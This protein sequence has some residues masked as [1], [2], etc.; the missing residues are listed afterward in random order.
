MDIEKK[1]KEIFELLDKASN[2]VSELSTYIQVSNLDPELKGI[3]KLEETDYNIQD[4]ISEL[5]TF[6]L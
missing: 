6:F 1:K 2:K 5:K 3:N 4:A